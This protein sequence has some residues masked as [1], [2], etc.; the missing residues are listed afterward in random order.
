MP[1]ALPVS[2]RSLLLVSG[3]AVL[4]GLGGCQTPHRLGKVRPERAAPAAAPAAR[5]LP[6]GSA[7]GVPEHLL[8]EYANRDPAPDA[9]VRTWDLPAKSKRVV[10]ELLILAARDDSSRLHNV[11]TRAARWGIPDRREYDARPVFDGDDG[12]VFLDNLR[13]ASSRLGRKENL[14][15]PP[16]MPPAAQVYVRNGAEPMWCFYASDDSLDI[17]AF[18]LVLEGGSAKIDYI[19]LLPERPSRVSPR[20]GPQPPPM[21]PIVRRGP[22]PPNLPPRIDPNQ[23]GAIPTI[24]A[25]PAN[26]GQ[27]GTPPVGADPGKPD[28][29]SEPGK[30]AAANPLPGDKPAGDKP[31][32]PPAAK[33]PVE[34]KPVEPAPAPAPA[35]AN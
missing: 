10:V 27:P 28:P 16:I 31:A 9:E 7:E 18:K 21:T 13:A 8:H 29:S 26:P 30:P 25:D 24:P 17:L 2:L 19:G 32:K 1:R 6:E 4:G 11:L 12:R 3:L 33:K 20:P 15:C 5:G 34:P 22:A 14:N 35:P 23:P